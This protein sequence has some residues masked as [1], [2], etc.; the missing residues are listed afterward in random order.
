VPRRAEQIAKAILVL[1][2]TRPKKDEKGSLTAIYYDRFGWQDH[3][4]FTRIY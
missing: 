2:A 3:E 1:Q 4:T